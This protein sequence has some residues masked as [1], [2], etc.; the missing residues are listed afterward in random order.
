DH[1]NKKA[2]EDKSV[3]RY[4][5]LKRKPQTKAQARK[6]MMIYLKNV[7]GFKMDYFKGIFL[8]TYVQSLRNTLTQTWISCKRQRSRWMKRIVEHSRG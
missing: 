3:K 2:K 7:A 4:Q 1:V 6:N 5:A 8:M